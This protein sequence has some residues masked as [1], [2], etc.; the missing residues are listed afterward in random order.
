M[1]FID[2]SIELRNKTGIGAYILTLMKCLDILNLPYKNIELNLSPKTKFKYIWQQLWMNTYLL[3]YTFLKK[4]EIMIFPSFFMPS[5]TRKK[6]KYITVVHD[7]CAYRNDEMSKYSC[8]IYK[9]SIHTAIKRADIIVTVSETTKNDLVKQYDINPCRIKV[10]HNSIGEHFLKAE[11]KQNI[12]DKYGIEQS[13]YILSVATLNKRKNI[14]ELIKAFESISDK[15]PD[16]RLVLVGGMGNENREKLTK[17]PNI[18]FTG[19]IPDEDI[20][21]L[22]KN[23]MFYMY[24]SLYEG[25]GTPQIEAQYSGC[26][27]LCSYIPV[28]REIAGNGAEFC[29]PNAKSIAEKIEYLINNPK[30]REELVKLGYENV[31]RFDIDEIAKQLKEVISV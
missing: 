15:Y 1:I 18:I 17:H 10:I 13:K 22:Y 12:L 14:P 3:I 20:P 9:R 4:P 6:T 26:P 19:Y 31:K 30:R 2:T 5:F 23:A 29:E 8:G 28:F 7:L 25:F 11:Y 27:M 21:I 24:P 16:L